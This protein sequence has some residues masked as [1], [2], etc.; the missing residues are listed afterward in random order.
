FCFQKMLRRARSAE[1]M[2][3]DFLCFRKKKK[4]LLTSKMFKIYDIISKILKIKK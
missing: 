4:H 1:E 2:A 3:I